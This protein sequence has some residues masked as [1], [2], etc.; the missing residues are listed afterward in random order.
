MIAEP[1]G[2]H[3]STGNVSD[4]LMILSEVGDG[5]SE[6]TPK[7]GSKDMLSTWTTPL[8]QSEV[9]RQQA[10]HHKT[11]KCVYETLCPQLVS[12]FQDVKMSKK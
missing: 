8:S 3:E 11:R 10:S 5:S 6:S 7:I 9:L 4:E 12:H 1:V 2:V